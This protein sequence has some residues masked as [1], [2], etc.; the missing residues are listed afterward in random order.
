MRWYCAVQA[1]QRM[2]YHLHI[3][4]PS[5]GL[6]ETCV[7]QGYFFQM[8]SE[9]E[10]DR[11]CETSIAISL[12]ELFPEQDISK[13]APLF[14]NGFEAR[15]DHNPNK[16]FGETVREWTSSSVEAEEC[17]DTF[18]SSLHAKRAFDTNEIWNLRWW[19]CHTEYG[20]SYSAP[21]LDELIV[22]F[23]GAIA[24]TEVL[25]LQLESRMAAFFFNI[26]KVC[27]MEQHFSCTLPEA[28]TRRMRDAMDAG[29]LKKKAI[30]LVF[31]DKTIFQVYSYEIIRAYK[32]RPRSLFFSG[33][34]KKLAQLSNEDINSVC[35]AA[36]HLFAE[37]PWLTTLCIPEPI[38]VKP[39]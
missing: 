34:Y 22:Y 7:K 6:A 23:Q 8:S 16:C 31:S 24:Q 14:P 1:S 18:E 28:P 17:D 11:F 35:V 30:L 3:K 33:I 26:S 13:L 29:L 10:D 37:S 5:Q 36:P 4:A 12:Q 38:T 39:S 2:D 25:A 19:N 32:P 20:L 9:F 27:E 15:L 21:T